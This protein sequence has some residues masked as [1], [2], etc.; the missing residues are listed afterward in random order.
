MSARDLAR[1]GQLYLE[2]GRWRDQQV[3]PAAWV[4]E[5]LEKHTDNPGGASYGYLWW[6]MPDGSY[7]ATGTGGQIRP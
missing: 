7:L 3:V 6:I 2:S 5:S 1:F 4:R